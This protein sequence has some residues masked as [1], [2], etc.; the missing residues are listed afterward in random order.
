M[1]KTMHTK[2]QGVAGMSYFFRNFIFSQRFFMVTLGS[3]NLSCLV[4]RLVLMM[5][6]L[7]GWRV[8]VCGL[9]NK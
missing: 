6:V 1:A 7:I 5:G 8:I 4:C 9:K 3:I 2:P